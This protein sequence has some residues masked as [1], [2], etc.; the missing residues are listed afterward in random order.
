MF[1]PQATISEM[2]E[3]IE[4]LTETR[5]KLASMFGGNHSGPKKKH[6]RLSKDARSRIAEA[7]R[8]RWA[9]TR[10]KKKNPANVLAGSSGWPTDPEARRKESMRRRR[11]AAANRAKG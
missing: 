8:K 9:K 10:A 1:D 11:V 2:N 4:L 7:Q 6:P 3:Q 5:D